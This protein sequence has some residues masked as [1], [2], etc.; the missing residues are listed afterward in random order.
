MLPTNTKLSGSALFTRRSRKKGKGSGESHVE[1]GKNQ[2]LHSLNLLIYNPPSSPL[3]YSVLN[4]VA[5]EVFLLLRGIFQIKLRNSIKTN[6]AI[7][8]KT[9]LTILFL[10]IVRL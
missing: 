7:D 1:N 5:L 4:S 6:K 10:V 3:K 2:L 8:R 9:N